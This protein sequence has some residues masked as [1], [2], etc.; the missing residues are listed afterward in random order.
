MPTSSNAVTNAKG[1]TWGVFT[2]VATYAFFAGVWILLSDQAMGLLVSDPDALVRASMAKG[3]LFVAITS[4]LLYGLVKRLIGQLNEAHRIDAEQ[5]RAQKLPPPMLVAIAESSDDAIFAKDEDGRY[6]LFNNAA[7]RFVGKPADEVIGKDD[8]ALFPPEQAAFIMAIDRRIRESGRTE[9]NE[10]TLRTALG[11]RVFLATKGPLR[12]PGGHVFG[13]FGISRDITDR[14]RGEE[15]VRNLADDMKA[16]LSAI[17]DLLFEIDAEGRYLKVRAANES[18]LA[19]PA[20]AL[21]GRKVGEV[22]P[23]EAAA[24]VMDAIAA[25]SRA[26]TDYG[27]AL[28]LPLANGRRDFEL[29]VARKASAPGTLER[30]VVLSRDISARKAVEREIRQRND[31]LERFNRAA[32]ERELRMIALKREVNALA[33]ELGRAPP[34]DLSF[35]DE[36]DMRHT[37]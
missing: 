28:V 14:R 29:S 15:S 8:R 4:L 37:P 27:R 21:L 10:E 23:P 19:A 24:T 17:P 31:E 35:A 22:L 1:P 13:T 32:T 6:L 7:S 11:E 20:D 18:Q 12:R 34:Y 30:F 36:P 2:V 33:A 9:T 5:L 25:A 16:T 3:W 26:G